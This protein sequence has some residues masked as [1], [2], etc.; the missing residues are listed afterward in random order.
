MKCQ[1]LEEAHSFG[2]EFPWCLI[3]CPPESLVQ[4][5]IHSSKGK[6]DR[7]GRAG[8]LKL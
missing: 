7:G 4:D 5:G 2:A 6:A 3:L 8:H 1:L